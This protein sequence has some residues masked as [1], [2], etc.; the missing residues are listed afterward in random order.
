MPFQPLVAPERDLYRFWVVILSTSIFRWILIGFGR[1]FWSLFN[2]MFITFCTPFSNIDFP[3]IFDGLFSILGCPEPRFL[4][5]NK[6]FGAFQPL[7]QK[8]NKSMSLASVLASFWKAFGI[9]LVSFFGIIFCIDFGM[10]FSGFLDPFGATPGD[11]FALLD[12]KGSPRGIQK[13][14]A[15]SPFW[16]SGA[17]ARPEASKTSPVALKTSSVELKTGPV[18]RATAHFWNGF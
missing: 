17:A 14:P 9:H 12:H 13:H 1:L 2:T 10:A 11:F 8:H 3:L 5:E 18:Q 7:S 6:Q 16:H 4:L 15:R